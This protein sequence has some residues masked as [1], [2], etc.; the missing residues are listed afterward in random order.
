MCI[1]V[2]TYVY[3]CIYTY[4]YIYIYIYIYI[5]GNVLLLPLTDK[6]QRQKALN[7]ILSLTL[8]APAVPQT[9]LL[10]CGALPP[11]L[12]ALSVRQQGA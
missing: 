12:T 6:A 8:A 3:I 7:A 11:E 9:P 1:Y 5:L 2:Y 10:P 4:N